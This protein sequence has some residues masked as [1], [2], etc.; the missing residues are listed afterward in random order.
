MNS[1]FVNSFLYD[2]LNLLH[3]FNYVEIGFD[4]NLYNDAHT[5]LTYTDKAGCGEYTPA[6]WMCFWWKETTL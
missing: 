6:S 2:W 3:K 1:A 4:L 5:W